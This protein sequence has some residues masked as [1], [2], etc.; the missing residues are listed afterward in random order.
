MSIKNP[1][2]CEVRAVIRFL[3]AEGKTPD[4]I[5]SRIKSIYGDGVMNRTNVFKWCREFDEGR[6]NIHDDQRCGRSSIATDE[7]GTEKGSF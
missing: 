4:E 7:F 2:K 6:M 1:A 5:F 3:N